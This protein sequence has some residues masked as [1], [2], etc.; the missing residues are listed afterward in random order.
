[1]GIT[2]NDIQLLNS[3]SYALKNN[4]T[5]AQALERTLSGMSPA[6]KN[7]AAQMQ[8]GTASVNSLTT[9]TK[10]AQLGMKVLQSVMNIGISLAISY[11]ISKLIQ[12]I[13]DLIETEEEA[14]QKHEELIQS[15]NNNIEQHKKEQKELSAI[16]K[17]YKNYEDYTSYTAE[18]KE[19]LK[20]IQDQLIETYGYE[21]SGI[22]LVNG[23]YDEQIQKLKELEMERE[24]SNNANYWALYDES[25]ADYENNS[26]FSWKNKYTW[27]NKDET[28]NA[29]NAISPLQQA[30][31]G[32]LDIESYTDS[33]GF[34]G[35]NY[36]REITYALKTVDED[37]N[38]LNAKQMLDQVLAIQERLNEIR[39]DPSA[40]MQAVAAS[41]DFLDL[42][43][44]VADW[45]T[46]YN[47][48]VQTYETTLNDL[49]K[50][51]AHTQQVIIDGESYNVDNVTPKV[52]QEFRKK[53]IESWQTKDPELAKAIKDYLDE[54]FND[55]A[56]MS[57]FDR[58]WYSKQ[59]TI[60]K[61]IA[62]QH[63]DMHKGESVFDIND[64]AE[65]IEDTSKAVSS[66]ATAYKQISD[67]EISTSEMLT[68]FKKYP[69]LS[70]YAEDTDLLAQK[71]RELAMTEVT[72]LIKQLIALRD[73]IK[74][75]DQK[76]QID[77]LVNSLYRL[78]SLSDSIDKTAESVKKVKVSDYIKYE[79]NQL[80]HI[81]DKLETEKDK[82]NE[83]LD[84]LKAQK[85][86]L[87]K[88]ISEYEKTADIV[89]KYIDK[90]QIKPLEDRKT[91][92]EEYY[93][94]EIE[95]L[96]EENEERDRNI[97]LQEKQA[98]LANARKS[99]VRVY[100]ETSGW[101]YEKDVNAIEKAEQELKDLE[102]EISIDALEKQREK[103]V[104]SIEE[105]I[106]AW[107]NYKDEWQKQVDAITEADEELIAS[108]VLGSEWHEKIANKDIN[109]MNDYGSRYAAY[110]NRLKNQVNVEINNMEK[111]IKAR[112]KEIDKWKGYKTELSNLNDDI[113]DENA[114]YL[115]NFSAFVQGE[116]VTWQAR[117]AMIK[118][119]IEKL[120][121]LEAEANNTSSPASN[122][123]AAIS[124]AADSI[125]GLYSVTYDGKILNL[126]NNQ[127]QAEKDMRRLAENIVKKRV[128]IS[129]IPSG[130][131]EAMITSIIGNMK[132]EKRFAKGGISTSTG[133]AWL[134]GS[135]N[136]SEV[137]FNSRQAK[138]LYNLVHN[139][140]FSNAIKNNILS[141]LKSSL[142]SN[143]GQNNKSDTINSINISFPNANINAT[144]YDS[145][146]GFMDRYTNDLLLKMQVG[147]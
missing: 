33:Y 63:I 8:S 78:G 58:Q 128:D 93:N 13:D 147:L 134:D 69:E 25:K 4:V 139:G 106:E 46:Y 120:K 14:K 79:E 38:P 40:E 37:G 99:K 86:E 39:L 140:D 9:A 80:D 118:K 32:V 42:Q 92:I 19:H 6:A 27:A 5:D 22:D 143:I 87:E 125:S 70:Q 113:A 123:S 28:I 21:A 41:Q 102:N 141:Q 20:T 109:I 137:I 121:R 146:K 124:N 52:Y 81:I 64:Y 55:V 114:E 26:G 95:K 110:N 100:S 57:D 56:Y 76:S 29:S 11:G 142:N 97:D 35:K 1:M 48:E 88:I 119:N 2:N 51:V 115:S 47:Q 72:P 44:Q 68:L 91:E 145:F 104:K 7:F 10:A 53:L 105:Q 135:K 98:A 122:I 73:T 36:T 30:L 133:L 136:N 67:G 138:E 17:E 108:K 131:L 16:I 60:E 3:Y 84:N 43:T 94:A 24:K 18:E 112:E 82:Q 101:T 103:E 130:A 126:Y 77:G 90:T 54:T 61:N 85:E 96:K 65:S 12:F 23:K 15:I 71:I 62:K 116:N 129:K 66:L 83:I 132:I 59:T 89:G 144:D 45:I 31:N 50:S 34:G 107:E 127:E 74:D 111:A 117:L 75:P 49:A